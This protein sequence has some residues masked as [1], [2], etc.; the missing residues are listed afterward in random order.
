MM[1]GPGAARA[2][3]LWCGLCCH[4]FR[5]SFPPIQ[6]CID[7]K[8]VFNATQTSSGN[9]LVVDNS[10]FAYAITQNDQLLAPTAPAKSGT[11]RSSLANPSA[12][13]ATQGGNRIRGDHLHARASHP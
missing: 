5:A 11:S 8:S 13:P 12:P 10:S 7:S 9:F 4:R 3:R 6:I 1:R 2:D